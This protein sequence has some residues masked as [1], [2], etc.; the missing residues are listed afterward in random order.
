MNVKILFIFL[1][2]FRLSFAQ[3]GKNNTVTSDSL[4]LNL[5]NSIQFNRLVFVASGTLLTNWAL[6]Q[7][8]RNVW[9]T[10]QKTKFHLYRGYKRNTGYWDFGWHDSLYGHMDKLGHFF[11]SRLLC[12]LFADVYQWIGFNSAT[13]LRIASI[14]SFLLM[15]E[16]EV[17]D[18]FFEEWGFSLADLTANSVGSFSPYISHQIPVFERFKLKLS[19][20]PS[21]FL[22]N[23]EYYIKDYAGMTFWLSYDLNR[24]LPQAIEPHWPDFLNISLGY[25]VDKLAHG[26]IELYLAPDIN[27]TKIYHGNN[28]LLKKTFNLFDYFHFPCMTLKL[29]PNKRF[30]FIYF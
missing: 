12:N 15:L 6:Y 3:S 30:Y 21:G 18:S 16:I 9:W 4:N 7:P 23:E 5:V 19:Y 26:N 27:W 25:G 24:D 2:V 10:E 1:L 20:H 14:T 13:S 28:R 8:F 29:T 22:D 17:Y 11:S